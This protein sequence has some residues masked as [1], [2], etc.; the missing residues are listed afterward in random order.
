MQAISSISY[1]GLWRK[2]DNQKNWKLLFGNRSS[3]VSLLCENKHLF[4]FFHLYKTVDNFDFIEFS[5]W[6]GQSFFLR[7][8][9]FSFC[10]DQSKQQFF[11]QLKGRIGNS[12][13]DHL[14]TIV[15]G[16][17]LHRTFLLWLKTHSQYTFWAFS[18]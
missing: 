6:R 14:K 7:H 2:T 9:T 16:V 8:E 13:G 15:N 18:M 11:G 3:F 12:F 10:L 1:M 5:D 4:C 17:Y